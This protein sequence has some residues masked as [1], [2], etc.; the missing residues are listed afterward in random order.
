M[1]RSVAATAAIIA[2]ALLASGCATNL[3]GSG[4]PTSSTSA[5]LPPI[6]ANP[7]LMAKLPTRI[8]NSK[9]IVVGTSPTYKP[10][11]FLEGDKVSGLDIDLFE[12]VGQRL[13]VQIEWEQSQFDQILIG[14]QAQKYDA[15][16]S[17]FT[18]TPER[19]K[20]VNMVSYLSA[21][22]LWTV[23]KG[24]PS[25][26]EAGK[27]CGRTIAVQ[28]GVVQELELKDAQKSCGANPIKI[29]SFSDQGEATAALVSGRAQVMAADSPIALYAV[30]MN[31]G[32]IEQ[33]GETYD[34]A[35]YGTVVRKDDAQFAEAIKTAFDE[36]K[37]SGHYE[38]I[39][40][41][42]NQTDGAIKAFE[43]NPK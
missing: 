21:G 12:A 26:V 11:E 9:K 40:A 35:P 32:T 3:S 5:S 25:K 30:K 29:L 7:E 19:I 23:Q 27:P 43:V 41:K 2:T 4:L 16:V 37:T 17:A 13:G 20:S 10:V 33:L 14:I 31:E 28:T 39:L 15:G 22:S 42:W 8:Q 36:L 34:A 18:V 38:Q 24:N 1:K 6:A